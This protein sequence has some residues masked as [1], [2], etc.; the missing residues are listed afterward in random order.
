MPI[1][2]RQ[3]MLVG[4]LT[5][6]GFAGGA[7][8]GSRLGPQLLTDGS[9]S[10]YAP[11]M[12]LL[13]GIAIG[14][15]LAVILEGLAM[16][17][18]GRLVRG[19]AAGTVDAVGGAAVLAMLGL[20][21]AWV[22][23]AVALHAPGLK[24]F[25]DD[26]ENSVILSALNDV[27]PASG[28][29]LNVLDEINRLP[30]LRGPSADVAPPNKG[31]VEDP[32]I[33]AAS[34][35]VVRVLGTACGLNISG[36]GWVADGE[37]VVTNA[38]VVAGVDDPRI[39]LRDGSELAA[40]A[41]AFNPRNDIAVL[42]VPGIGAPVLTLAEQTGSGRPG[43]VAGY[44]GAGEFSLQP[45]RLGTTG[46][47]QSQDAYGRGPVERAMTSFRADVQSGN[48]GGPVIGEDGQVL[49]TVFASAVESSPPEG[50]GVPNRVVSEILA[51]ADGGSVSTGACAS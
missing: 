17:L 44:P 39:A 19:R 22:I 5:L 11:L 50:L 38:H 21:I 25:R 18:R 30:T 15:A 47:V 46:T 23:G 14:G 35:G 51:G 9:Q 36:S 10:P 34:A 37:R 24:Q 42:S 45:A 26:V 40:S 6:A 33:Q 7:L 12:A 8:L 29:L 4:T 3:G 31:I 48:S 2:W 1:G 41:V 27:L 49:A 13:G 16:G 43:A 32:E 20:G 28:P